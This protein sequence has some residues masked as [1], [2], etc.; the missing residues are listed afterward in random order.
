VHPTVEE[1]LD[2]LCPYYIGDDDASQHRKEEGAQLIM[3]GRKLMLWVTTITFSMMKKSTMP[4]MSIQ[5]HAWL[6]KDLLTLEE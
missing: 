5:T 3:V 1:A 4:L 2:H 6:T